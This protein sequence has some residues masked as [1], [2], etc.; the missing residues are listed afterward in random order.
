MKILILI[1]ARFASSR[2]PGKPLVDIA[3]KS[4]LQRV[5]ERC[6][7]VLGETSVYVATDD[8]RIVD[9]CKDHGMQ[10][11]LTSDTC[12]T[13]TDRLAE[14]ARK[15]KADFYINVQGDEPMVRPADITKVINAASEFPGEILN[16]TCNI[17]SDSDFYSVNV[18]KAVMRPDGRLLYMSRAPIPGNKKKQFVWGKKQVCIYGF[19][20]KALEDFSTS[21][22]K[23]P[24]EEQEDIEILRFL[25]M[26]YDV[27]MIEVSGSSVAVDVPEDVAR[28]IEALKA[29]GEVP[30]A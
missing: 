2:Y 20:P 8:Q 16:A 1:P 5:W 24:L 27:R 4:L 28:V 29:S 3:G 22:E 9:H 18:P 6:V 7:P 15:L 17:A 19:P 12:L 26:G 11:V 10:W 25:E 30:G 13:G 14:A 23:S 21:E